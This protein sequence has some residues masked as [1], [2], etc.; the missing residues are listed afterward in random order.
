MTIGERI[1]QRRIELGLSQEEIAHKLGNKSRASVSTVEHDKEDLT[2]DRIR[3]YAEALETTPAFLMGWEDD[4]IPTVV[5]QMGKSMSVDM[6]I[7]DR[8][9]AEA[10]ELYKRYVNAIPEIQDAVSRLLKSDE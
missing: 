8:D 2:T 9:M 3:K 4:G 6:E 7:S 5:R 1:K 10:L